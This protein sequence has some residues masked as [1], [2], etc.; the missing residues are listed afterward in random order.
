M[1]QNYHSVISVHEA[2]AIL[3]QKKEKARIIAGGTDLILELRQ[4]IRK[5]VDT[6]IDI[7]RVP[8]LDNIELDTEGIVHISPMV[9]HNHCLDSEIIRESA[10]PLAQACLSI[11]APQIRN[12]GTVAGNLVTASPANDTITPLIALDAEVCLS[13]K[14]NRRILRL[15]DFYSGLRLTLLEPDEML[16]EIRF[17]QMSKNQKGIFKKYLL[18]KAHAI[19]LVNI[20]IILTL[21]ENLIKY[22]AIALGAVAPTVIRATDAENYL[23]GKELSNE[24]I[25][26]TSEIARDSSVP[27]SDIRGSE[28]Y[29]LRLMKILM[30]EGLMEIREGR[31]REKFPKKPILLWGKSRYKPS[32]LRKSIKHDNSTPVVTRING[33]NYSFN[34]GQTTTLLNLV[35][36]EAGLIGTKLGCGEGECG[37]CTLLM[38]GAPVLSCLIPAPRAH[39]AELI[40]IEGV[41]EGDELHPIQQA[42]IQEGAVQCGYCTP[43]FI[44]SAVK[45]LQE[46][47]NPTYEQIQ[48]GLAGNLCRCTGYYRIIAAVEK[49]AETING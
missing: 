11:G 35:R 29:R 27:I 46:I 9:T 5:N 43:G 4:G 40:T 36:E 3:S 47:K 48:E 23:I 37:A 10:F 14:N 15:K 13:T 2:L 24:V 6:L 41:G 21:E 26:K 42:F 8:G 18:R 39:Q 49:A 22:A 33:K 45:L 38:D 19:S 16:T 31:E 17:K 32:L 30:T 12:M 44:M 20:T 1:W 34:K 7:S 25:E 28:A